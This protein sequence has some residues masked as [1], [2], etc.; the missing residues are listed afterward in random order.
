[1]TRH[2]PEVVERS[3]RA[4]F[5]AGQISNPYPRH[6]SLAFAFSSILYPLRLWLVLR[7]PY[8]E[9]AHRAYPVPPVYQSGLGPAL[10][11]VEVFHLYAEGTPHLRQIC[12]QYL[13][14]SP[15]LLVQVF[16]QV[17]LVLT[18]GACNDSL[19]L[20]LPLNSSPLSTFLLVDT[21]SAHASSV[22]LSE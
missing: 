12:V 20:T 2:P 3:V 4:R 8:P 21:V 15:Y 5:H 19:L 9:G 6:Y 22:F 14:L 16:Q 18:H 11:A 10:S 17:S 1:M 7:P 13:R